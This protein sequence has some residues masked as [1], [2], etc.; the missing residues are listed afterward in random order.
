MDDRVKIAVTQQVINML[1][2][3]IIEGYGNESFEGWCEDRDVFGIDF[4]LF[5]PSENKEFTQECKELM[6]EIAPIVD[7][8]TYNYL[9]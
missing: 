1:F 7:K 4:S 8:L 2:N 6:K 3:N 5:P 9:A